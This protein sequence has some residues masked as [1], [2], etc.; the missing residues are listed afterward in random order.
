[1][2]LRMCSRMIGFHL[3][4]PGQR[5]MKRVTSYVNGFAIAIVLGSPGSPFDAHAESGPAP[6]EPGKAFPKTW[7]QR[8]QAG[9][10]P[11][12]PAGGHVETATWRDFRKSAGTFGRL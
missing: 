2:I 8:A 6:G 5:P 1:M 3:E 11:R 9:G 12:V 4:R 10:Y 7:R